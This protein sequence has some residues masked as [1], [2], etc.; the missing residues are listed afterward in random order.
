MWVVLSLCCHNLLYLGLKYK[1][2]LSFT[3]TPSICLICSGSVTET[4]SAYRSPGLGSRIC[5][6]AYPWTVWGGMTTW[7]CR[8]TLTCTAAPHGIICQLNADAGER[9][10]RELTWTDRVDLNSQTFC[11]LQVKLAY[12]KYINVYSFDDLFDKI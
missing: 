3:S 11:I 10:F 12:C 1:T 9:L 7:C 2:K 6:W 8:F 5:R 4:S